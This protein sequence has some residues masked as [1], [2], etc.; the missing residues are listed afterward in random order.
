MGKNKF[1]KFIAF[2]TAITAIGGACYVYRDK[3]KESELFQTVVGK[4]AG[5]MDKDNES[6]DFVFDD[7]DFGDDTLFD[8]NAKNN[9]EYTSIT[10]TSTHT[11]DSEDTAEETTDIDTATD[12]DD[13]KETDTELK[14]TVAED[15]AAPTENATTDSDTTD[16]T[17]EV[18]ESENAEQPSDSSLDDIVVNPS[19]SSANANTDAAEEKASVDGFEYEGLSDVSEDPD[20]L[21]DQDKLDF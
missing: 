18:P 16:D 2:T 8:D 5:F 6:E 14:E 7:D 17:K 4:L 9:R 11:E 12:T 20:V 3:I 15:V 13:T 1:G 10:I 21:E 19:I